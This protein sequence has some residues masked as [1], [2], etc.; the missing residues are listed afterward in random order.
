MSEN[1]KSPGEWQK[2]YE[3]HGGKPDLQL[4]DDETVLFHPK[5]GFVS[6][7]FHDEILEIHHMV[8]EGKYWQK[9]LRE[10]MNIHELKKVRWYTQRNPK[11]WMRKYGGHIRGYYMECELDE[12]KE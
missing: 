3:E 6:F 11:A 9:I 7:F 1:K 8:G 12:I 2:W 10:V 5:H 4:W